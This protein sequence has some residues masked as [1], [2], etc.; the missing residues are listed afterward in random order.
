MYLITI[1]S[2]QTGKINK[3]NVRDQYFTAEIGW[4][5]RKRFGFMAAREKDRH[6]IAVGVEFKSL[7]GYIATDDG[8]K[9]LGNWLEF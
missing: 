1:T 6:K 2:E 8:R 5:K 3:V 4:L 9:F 7:N